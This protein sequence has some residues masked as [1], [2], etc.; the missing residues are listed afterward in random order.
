[1]EK[2]QETRIT[3]G[4]VVNLKA[5]NTI[6]FVICQ[7]NFPGRKE[8]LLL[9]SEKLNRVQIWQNILTHAK[10]PSRKSTLKGK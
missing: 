4:F 10:T 3:L 2:H 1:L 5:N 9:V 6:F 8:T 7:E